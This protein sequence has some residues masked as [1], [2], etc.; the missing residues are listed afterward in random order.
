MS[1]HPG[2][3]IGDVLPVTCAGAATLLDLDAVPPPAVRRLMMFWGLSPPYPSSGEAMV[4]L[5]GTESLLTHRW[6]K[7]DS[8][9]RSRAERSESRI[10]VSLDLGRANRS[11]PKAPATTSCGSTASTWAKTPVEVLRIGC[12]AHTQPIAVKPGRA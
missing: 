12:L 10:V 3:R 9:H 5:R 11:V 2:D 6:S 4:V 8:N 7:Q 1:T